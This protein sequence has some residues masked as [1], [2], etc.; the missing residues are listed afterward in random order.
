LV[1][2]KEVDAII[3][4]QG[5]TVTAEIHGYIGNAGA[6]EAFQSYAEI[7]FR[8]VGGGGEGEGGRKVKGKVI[9]VSKVVNPGCLSRIL[10]FIHPGYNNS[11]KRGGDLFSYLFCSSKYHKIDNY[12]IF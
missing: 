3:D 11:N 8:F 6:Y 10:I 2:V 4:K 9:E 5:N 1:Y 12:F 7:S